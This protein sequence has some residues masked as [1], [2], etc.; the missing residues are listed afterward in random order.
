MIHLVILLN[1]LKQKTSSD[2][3]K[4]LQQDDCIRLPLIF[5]AVSHG[6]ELAPNILRGYTELVAKA[7]QGLIP[8]PFLIRVSTYVKELT[9]TNG[10]EYSTAKSVCQ[11]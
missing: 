4:R 8:Q 10:Y 11:V 5:P 6:Q 7:S 3:Q 9:Y 2:E 1:D